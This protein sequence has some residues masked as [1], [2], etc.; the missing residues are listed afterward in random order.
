MQLGLTGLSNLKR[1]VKLSRW[2]GMMSYEIWPNVYHRVYALILK[3]IL[4]YKQE[5]IMIA[6]SNLVS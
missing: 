3:D 1:W 5:G 2:Q 4:R 6:R